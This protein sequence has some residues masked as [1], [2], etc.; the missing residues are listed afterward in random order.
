MFYSTTPDSLS[1]SPQS[2]A[3]SDF[4]QGRLEKMKTSI[5]ACCLAALLVTSGC[6]TSR[7]ATPPISLPA[8]AEH[9]TRDHSDCNVSVSSDRLRASLDD[10]FSKTEHKLDMIVVTQCG[11]NL[12]TRGFNGFEI[13]TLHEIQSATKTFSAMLIGA[14]MQDGLI[15]SL[16]QPLS[17]LLPDY[18]ELMAGSK[19]KITL[20]QV[21]TMTT[22]LKWV[23]FGDGNSFERIGKAGDS[24][25]FVLDEPLV[26]EPGQVF[27]YNTGSSHLLSAIITQAT[28]MSAADYADARLF[29]ALGITE[30]RWPALSDGRS[31]GGWDMYMRPQDM[32]VFGQMILDGGRIGE[33]QLVPED[34][35]D[36][37][38]VKHVE[39]YYGPGYG[40]QMWIDNSYGTTD[41]AAARG[42]GGQDVFVFDELDAVVVF[43]GNIG[44]PGEN[45]AHIEELLRETI[46]PNL[47]R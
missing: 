24:V 30:Y 4:D 1:G 13:D 7:T 40:F 11:A 18:A 34:F 2:P 5:I 46:I 17:E 35:I 42:Y 32:A 41:S 15:K 23:D 45:N 16:D 27:F 25:A 38:T 9:A 44:Y 36:A 37:A 39:T 14:A 47:A 43:N 20:R 22:G 6:T 29:A 21:L 10:W 3:L 31:K 26:S 12:Y 8:G 28:G 19:A 33:Q